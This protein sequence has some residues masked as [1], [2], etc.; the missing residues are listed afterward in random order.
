MNCRSTSSLCGLFPAVDQC[1]SFHAAS[2][3]SFCKLKEEK[4]NFNCFIWMLLK[5]DFEV[6]L[7]QGR[8]NLD[9]GNSSNDTENFRLLLF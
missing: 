8:A 4:W 1:V 5:G 9:F 2:L 6:C 7:S 3:D